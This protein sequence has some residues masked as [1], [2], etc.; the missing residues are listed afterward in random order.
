MNKK[1]IIFYIAL[2]LLILSFSMTSTN[3]DFDLWAR[4]I[5]GMGVV[6][7]HHVLMSDFLSYTPVHIWYD[8][9]WGSGVIFY[10]LLKYFGGYSLII[11]QSV[12]IFA[13]FLTTSLI[14]KVKQVKN[15]YNFLFYFFALMSIMPTLN[16]PIRCH[17][18]SFLFFTIFIY[19][20]EK[21]RNG[22][23]KILYLLPFLTIIWNNI[24]GGVT[25]GIGLILIFALGEFLN[26]KPIKHLLTAF[27]ISSCALIIN[28][29]G[30]NYIKFL[31]MANTMTRAEITEWW[32][33]FSKHQLTNFIMFK[34]F[35][36]TILGTE[37]IYLTKFI[38]VNKDFYEKQDKVKWIL[39][40]VTTYLAIAHVKLM[41][42]FV[43]YSLCYAYEDFYKLI[44]NIK[45]PIW[46]DKVIYTT[47][48]LLSLFSL[49]IKKFSIPIS[50]AVYPTKEIEFVKINKIKGNLLI[51]FGL[52]SYAS[53]KLYPQ[54]KIFM[55]GRY[56]EVYYDFMIP[57]L[58]RF[59]LLAPDW[60]DVLIKYK[61]D[62]MI[63]E[64]Y[65]PV[66]NKLKTSKEWKVVYEGQTFGVFIPTTDKQKKYKQPS[67]DDEYYKKT[68]FD[69][70]IKIKR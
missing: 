8:H 61:P 66:Y 59:Y 17:L 34:V 12:V 52:G 33:I 7:G 44:S 51:N 37:I 24:H 39:F 11:F 50:Y 49:T 45:L 69:T 20:L 65:Y 62:V 1:I 14:L 56:E 64:K 4:L 3:Y 67:N 48:I 42:F 54:N 47:V 2:F 58:K 38:K 25:S 23:Y 15:Q 29:W 28:P 32:G 30:I 19:I 9:E 21:A 55:D 26:R 35:L 57:M 53:Y 22:N 18:F 40:G 13:I 5:A 68:L 46:K 6:E 36:F 10:T 63:I 43:I 27:L 70:N 60:N 16:N 41:P 31:I